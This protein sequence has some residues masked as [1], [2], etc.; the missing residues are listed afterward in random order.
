M[1]INNRS[2]RW[3]ITLFEDAEPQFRSQTMHY[4][5]Y[6]RHICPDTG[7][8]HWHIFVQYKKKLRGGSVKKDF[9]GHLLCL[10][11]DDTSYIDDGHTA[12][13][14]PVE[15]GNL[16]GAGQRTDILAFKAAI[17]SG[18]SMKEIS[19]QHFQCWLK[20]HKMIPTYRTIQAPLYTSKY[21]KED[22]LVNIPDDQWDTHYHLWG[23]PDTGKTQFALAQFERPL[24]V[25]HQDH[26]V[27]FDINRHD[28][29]VMDEMS[30]THWPVNSV[31][32][33]LNKKDPAQV[34]VRYTTA[35][36]PAGVRIIFCSNEEHIFYNP[37]NPNIE[38]SQIE[39]IKA[40]VQVVHVTRKMFE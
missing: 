9:N 22:F 15:H 5:K 18:A 1:A 28:G 39:S 23:G 14:D 36:L 20:Y 33:L 40:K 34:H 26:L 16:A 37:G 21:K 2:T 10:H 7:R 35:L 29:I 24:Y 30:F 31:I 3:G 11:K 13:G 19:S 8:P 38:P 25:R 4:L 12:V 32:C 27:D 17:D 6:I